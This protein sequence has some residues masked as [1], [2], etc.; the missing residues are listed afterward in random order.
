MF[1]SVWGEQRKGENLCVFE[2][3]FAVRRTGCLCAVGDT[4]VSFLLTSI[5]CIPKVHG[6]CT[7]TLSWPKNSSH[8]TWLPLGVLHSFDSGSFPLYT[9]QS[10]SWYSKKQLAYRSPSLDANVCLNYPSCMDY[11]CL[12]CMSYCNWDSTKNP[13]EDFTGLVLLPVQPS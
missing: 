3:G 7:S 6:L 8:T 4:V 10:L 2:E 11:W 13:H 12:N 1:W 9:G 5:V